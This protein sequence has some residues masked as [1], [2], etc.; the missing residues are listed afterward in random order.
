V[1]LQTWPQLDTLVGLGSVPDLPAEISLRQDINRA[2]MVGG[3]EKA[4]AS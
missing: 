2:V 4:A 3:L 1:G